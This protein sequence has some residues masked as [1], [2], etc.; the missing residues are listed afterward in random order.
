MTDAY[1]SWQYGSH[2]KT[3]ACV[4]CHIPHDNPIAG[5]AFKATDGL[6]HSYVFTMRKEPQV[7]K[8]SKG[9]VPVVQSNCL[10]CHDEQLAMI[11][12]ASSSERACWDC[13]SNIHGT[14]ISISSSPPQLRPTLPQAGIELKKGNEPK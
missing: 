2:G 1:A 4:D 11:R 7:L 9:A 6:K 3:A 12:V 5:L 13:H 8:L 14:V 10:R